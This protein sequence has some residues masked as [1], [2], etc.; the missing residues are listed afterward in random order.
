MATEIPVK[1][2]NQTGKG[3]KKYNCQWWLEDEKDI[4]THVMAGL[5]EI[6]KRQMERNRRNVIHRR[7]YG[8]DLGNVNS[9]N[10]Y[11]TLKTGNYSDSKLRLNVVKAA[12]DTVTSKIAKNRPRPLFLTNKGNFPQQE[13]AKK[14]TQYV[15]GQFKAMD[16]YSLGQLVFRDAGI[17]GTGTLKIYKDVEGEVL[18][19]ERVL[20]DEVVVDDAEAVYNN[21]RCQ[22]QR[23]Y[24]HR[25]VLAAMFADEPEKLRMIKE[26]TGKG[27]DRNVPDN[28]EQ[29]NMLFT[30]EAWHLPS[31]P[32]AEDGM[33]AL[34]IENGTLFVEPYTK[35][36]FP[37]RT[38]YWTPPVIGYYGEGIVKEIAGIQLE[39]NY[40]LR[41]LQEA[42][43]LV[44]SPML[45]MQHGSQMMNKLT[46]KIGE[47]NYY[48]GQPPTWY[49][50]SAMSSEVYQHLW[51]L[52]QKAF[53][54]VGV[55]ELSATLKKPA[56]LESK[57]ALREYN[58]I[59]TERF[60]LVGQSYEN[61]YM[62]IAK[63]I[64]DLSRDM[65][66]DGIDMTVKVKG[67]D[68][69]ESIK[70]SD[71]DMD[72]DEYVM[73]IF[74]T[75][76]LPTTPA[77]RREAVQDLIDM[78]LPQ[79]YAFSLMDFPDIEAFVSLETSSLE[80]TRK[81]IDQI[82]TEGKYESPEPFMDLQLAVKEAQHAYCRGRIDDVEPER[83]ELLQ[84]WMSQAL[85]LMNAAQ[86]EAPAGP[87]APGAPPPMPTPMPG[88]P[89]A[90]PPAGGAP[91]APPTNGLPPTMQ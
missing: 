77:G 28:I 6:S 34:V 14:L 1:Y 41:Y 10:I 68:F 74:P 80:L 13:R 85:T 12:I 20:V 7:L 50:P 42:Q 25:N 69:I 45:F 55:S 24:V 26:A 40:L 89:M 78:G 9:T 61:F 67:K 84:R 33:H 62:D 57:P 5:T 46:N 2:Y 4:F 60:A 19:A 49:T 71:V 43:H 64:V 47:V 31:G 73:D 56:G 87:P 48:T 17:W 90:G 35:D 81:M 3:E 38:Q 18:R 70:W 82:I 30:A 16:I 83:L 11:S 88:A 75:S 44:C 32:N 51:A 79:Q 58:D 8:N 15:A 72:E 39:I 59:E 86:P 29:S 36:Y 37:I 52:Y 65:Y 91:P 21:P 63:I 23:R 76:F 22:Y 53:E 27:Y 66:E 54:I